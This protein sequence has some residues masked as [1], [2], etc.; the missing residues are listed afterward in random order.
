MSTTMPKSAGQD[1]IPAG[2]AKLSRL[3]TVER[4][5]ASTRPSRVRRSNLARVVVFVA[6]PYPQMMPAVGLG[7]T[8]GGP[9]LTTSW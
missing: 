4:V 1:D 2:G 7:G 3:T 8:K 5:P 6:G 9:V